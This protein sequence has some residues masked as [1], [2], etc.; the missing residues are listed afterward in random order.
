MVLQLK[1]SSDENNLKKILQTA[2][3]KGKVGSF[4]TEST[5][6]TFTRLGSK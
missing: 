5:G 2:V 1:S 3:D 6:I 4:E